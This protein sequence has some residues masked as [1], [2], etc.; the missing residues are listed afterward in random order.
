MLMSTTLG[1]S[2]SYLANKLTAILSGLLQSCSFIL[3]HEAAV[4]KDVSVQQ[5]LARSG[6]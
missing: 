2:W 4:E 3:K 6:T 1:I 5:K